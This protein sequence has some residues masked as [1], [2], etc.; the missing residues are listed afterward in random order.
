[1]VSRLLTNVSIGGLHVRSSQVRVIQKDRSH[2][3]AVFD[4]QQS[5]PDSSYFQSGEPVFIE[6]GWLS[7]SHVFLGYVNHIE[8]VYW[9]SDTPLRDRTIRVFCVGVTY[10]LN[11]AGVDSWRSS[12]ASQVAIQIADKFQL[13]IAVQESQRVWPLLAQAGM[14]YWSFLQKLADKV[15][16]VF[17]CNGTMLSFHTPLVVFDEQKPSAATFLSQSVSSSPTLHTFDP[18]SGE[19]APTA[20]A[21]TTRNTHG[22]NIRT[23][24]ATFSSSE[25][26]AGTVAN[27]LGTDPLFNTFNTQTVSDNS[28]D[29]RDTNTADQDRHRWFI[30]AEATTSGDASVKAGSPVLLLGLTDRYSGFWY[31]SGVEHV[32]QRETETY[33]MNLSLARDS[34]SYRYEVP[35]SVLPL[36]TAVD[37]YG[38]EFRQAGLSSY[39][40]SVS[41]RWAVGHSTIRYV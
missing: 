31:V 19:T 23:G 15:G 3:I 24:R 5:P 30:E 28:G 22:V 2:E 9:G 14:T 8:A 17:R 13:G 37:A 26:F 27:P 1:M 18:I 25:G 11:D 40:L 41:K 12:T 21:Y 38:D 32:M 7:R 6:Y 36:Q 39:R 16:Y 29:I 33:T 10:F 35:S 34:E 20:G 4:V